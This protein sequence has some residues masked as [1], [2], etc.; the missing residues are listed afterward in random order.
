MFTKEVIVPTTIGTIFRTATQTIR[1]IQLEE[2][3]RQSEIVEIC[4]RLVEIGAALREELTIKP[5]ML[6]TDYP[7]HRLRVQSLKLFHML[8][9]YLKEHHLPPS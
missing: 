3:A 4:R 8:K 1:Y 2:P 6:I 9:T 5:P 7:N